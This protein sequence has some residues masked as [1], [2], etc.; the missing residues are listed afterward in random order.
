MN[1]LPTTHFVDIKQ[2]QQTRTVLPYR[3]MYIGS[4]LKPLSSEIWRRNCKFA[5][6]LLANCEK[7]RQDKNDAFRAFAC[8]IDYMF[9]LDENTTVNGVVTVADLGHYSLKMQTY[10]SMEERRDFMQTWQVRT[11][12]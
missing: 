5:G 12:M 4:V 7:S 9:F 2:W 3:C 11:D 1:I 8:V 6:Y 10:I